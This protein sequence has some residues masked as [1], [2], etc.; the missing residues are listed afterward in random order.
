MLGGHTVRN[1]KTPVIAHS[2]LSGEVDIL[3]FSL[4]GLLPD[5]QS[6]VLHV[7]HGTLSLLSCQGGVPRMLAQQQFTT[8]ELMV[9]FPLLDAFPYY[10]PYEVLLASH[11]TGHVNERSIAQAK[12][13][14]LDAKVAGQWDQE[15]H[16]VRSLLSRARLKMRV[17]GIAMP[18]IEETGY[19]LLLESQEYRRPVRE[20]LL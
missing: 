17:F 18:S 16:A 14:L 8:S 12:K 7:S 5:G 19:I 10:C 1:V 9:L 4:K 3:H 13:R 11:A 6:L 15:V 20:V 2:S